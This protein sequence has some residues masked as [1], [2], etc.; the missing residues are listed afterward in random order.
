MKYWLWFLLILS[1]VGSYAQDT[2]VISRAPGHQFS[3]VTQ[4]GEDVVRQIYA[5]IGYQLEVKTVSFERES[6]LLQQGL[7]DGALARF[8]PI[9]DANPLLLRVEPE[10]AKLD[11]I[12]ACHKLTLCQLSENRSVGFF[13]GLKVFAALCRQHQLNCKEFDSD[14]VAAKAFNTGV[15]DVLVA[16]EDIHKLRKLTGHDGKLFIKT[17]KGLAGPIYHYVHKDN[18]HLIPGLSA[19]IQHLQQQGELRRKLL[20]IKQDMYAQS[21][22][23][24]IEEE[25]R[26]N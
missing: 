18:K 8:R 23:F 22:V 21:N 11:L 16:F 19:R 3:P 9:G 26:L 17:I 6:V 14:V 2:I 1:S 7:L 24:I 13:K 4:A 15:L 10:L 25:E 12:M 20:S 5:D